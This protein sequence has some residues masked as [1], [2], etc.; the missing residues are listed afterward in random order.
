ML[1]ILIQGPK[2][3][4]IDI[5]AFLKPLM[6]EMDILWRVG[7]PMFDASREDVFIC[8]AIFVTSND[9]PMFF[10]LSC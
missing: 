10:S 6:Q 8:R 7:L 9:Y 3:P 1:N 4:K 5:D 2:Q